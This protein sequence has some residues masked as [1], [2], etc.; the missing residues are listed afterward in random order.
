VKI[1]TAIINNAGFQFNNSAF[2]V[3]VKNYLFWFPLLPPHRAIRV[4][5]ASDHVFIWGQTTRSG[6]IRKAGSGT[7]IKI[8]FW[9]FMNRYFIFS[10]SISRKLTFVDGFL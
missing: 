10:W 2:A 6:K 1:F 8:G 7:G 5:C 9:F 4:I 3:F